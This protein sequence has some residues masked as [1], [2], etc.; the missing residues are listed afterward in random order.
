MSAHTLLCLEE[1]HQREFN[2]WEINVIIRNWIRQHLRDSW[3]DS[4]VSGESQQFWYC[5]KGEK[6]PQGLFRLH[7]EVL[8]VQITIHHLYGA[9]HHLRY[10]VII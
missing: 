9:S 5:C 8:E 4:V 7:L 2:Q 3:T 10:E 1:L 6:T